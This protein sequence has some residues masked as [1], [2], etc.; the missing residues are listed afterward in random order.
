LPPD[1]AATAA[2]LAVA[3]AAHCRLPSLSLDWAL[4]VR[5]LGMMEKD[6]ENRGRES[7]VGGSGEMAEG[8]SPPPSSIKFFIFPFFYIYF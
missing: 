8:K 4:G 7:G 5:V 1:V 6:E 3:L 2:G